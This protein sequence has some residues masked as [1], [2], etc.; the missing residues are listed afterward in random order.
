MRVASLHRD[1]EFCVEDG[2]VPRARRYTV[3]A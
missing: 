3:S 2:T 1:V